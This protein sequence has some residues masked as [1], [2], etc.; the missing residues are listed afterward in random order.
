MYL[1]CTTAGLRSEVTCSA[2]VSCIVNA[3]SHIGVSQ[4]EGSLRDRYRVRSSDNRERLGVEP[5]Q[6]RGRVVV[7]IIIIMILTID[8]IF[9][10]LF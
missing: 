7:G 4:E 1:K 9:M 5:L 6:A 10:A 2:R 3:S 8:G